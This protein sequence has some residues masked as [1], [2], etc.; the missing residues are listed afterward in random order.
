[1]N[2]DGQSDSI[3]G[4]RLDTLSARKPTGLHCRKGEGRGW[5][6]LTDTIVQLVRE[7]LRLRFDDSTILACLR[8]A[9]IQNAREMLDDVV[10]EARVKAILNL[11][12]R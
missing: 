4:S 3:I 10:D 9:N 6:E 5:Q 7:M 2:H 11:R 8:A 12:V 1:M